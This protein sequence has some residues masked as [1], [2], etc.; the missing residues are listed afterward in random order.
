MTS[1]TESARRI[2]G[3][4]KK[5]SW[6]ENWTPNEKGWLSLARGGLGQVSHEMGEGRWKSQ[7]RKNVY[8]SPYVEEPLNSKVIKRFVPKLRS[9]KCF[10]CFEILMFYLYGHSMYVSHIAISWLW[11]IL[12]VCV[13]V[14]ARAR[15]CVCVCVCVRQRE[16][17]GGERERERALI[18]QIF[19]KNCRNIECN[20]AIFAYSTDWWILL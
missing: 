14:C 11:Y 18:E 15:V 4:L 8:L 5:V 7:N 19:K 16:R 9:R 20:S 13:C 17:E 12:C 10:S 1:R 6:V 3:I 2:W